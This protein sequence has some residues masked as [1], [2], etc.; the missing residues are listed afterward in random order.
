MMTVNGK[1]DLLIQLTQMRR[2]DGLIHP[3]LC[4]GLQRK[5]PRFKKNVGGTIG[6][7]SQNNLLA[8]ILYVVGV[9]YTV[10]H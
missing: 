3:W 8:I 2:C 4:R 1:L 7:S 6:C 10:S 9:Q 5:E